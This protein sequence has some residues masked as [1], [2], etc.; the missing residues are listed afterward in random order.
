M[1]EMGHL[2]D[3]GLVTSG[4]SQVFVHNRLVV[5]LPADNPAGL[6]TLPGLARPGAEDVPAGKYARQALEN[7]NT[8][9]G[10]GFDSLVLANLVSNETNIRQVVTKVGLGEADA[11][12]AYLSDTIAAPD[13]KRIGI[14]D[15]YN[16]TA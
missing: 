9:Y 15:E 5:I 16:V 11:G 8:V 4:A 7:L 1:E 13:L 12:I 14:P 3:A 6:T 2:L 10:A